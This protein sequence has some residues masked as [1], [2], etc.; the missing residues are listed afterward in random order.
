MHV[1]PHNTPFRWPGLPLSK[2]GGS[3]SGDEA[4]RGESWLT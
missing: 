1:V 2:F 3:H 4:A